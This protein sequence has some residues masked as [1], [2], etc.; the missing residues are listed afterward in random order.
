MTLEET[1][2]SIAIAAIF[3]HIA[4][5]LILRAKVAVDP[6]IAER[7]SRLEAAIDKAEAVS[8]AEFAQNRSELAQS[9]E[10]YDARQTAGFDRFKTQVKEDL[11][12]MRGENAKKLDEMRKTVDERLQSSIEKKFNESFNLI[13]ERLEKVHL[14]LGE[15]Q[16]LARDVGGL[17]SALTNVKTRG[18]FGEIQL[19]AILEQILSKEQ[20]YEQ[21]AIGENRRVD[22]AVRLPG[23]SDEEL[24]L[25]IDSK[26][27]IE[28]YY[29]LSEAYEQN[30]DKE[31]IDELRKN[32]EVCVK[33]TAK[34]ISE[35]Y[36]N[37]PL[38][39]D[40]ALMFLPS[41][42][43]YAE[44]LRSRGLFEF[45]QEKYKITVAGPAN[46]A[47]FLNSLRIGFKTLA[48]E[49]RS[50]EVWSLLGKVKK[51]FGDFGDILD[52]VKKQL[53]AA[54]NAIDDAGTRTRAIERKLKGV[55]NSPL[56]DLGKEDLTKDVRKED[57]QIE[58]ETL[59]NREYSSGEN[60]NFA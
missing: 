58:N 30:A 27:P 40:F 55:E 35:K 4:I 20:Y 49:K 5:F 10:L 6:A 52:R 42:S 19:G 46:I 34:S 22:F 59:K 28:D 18:T 36:I 60:A 21:R 9:F 17:K 29:R 3:L 11:L 1:L 7:L 38:T 37:P 50:G 14:G 45:L 47:A 16:K 57:L 32:L 25:P 15:M 43:L 44:V 2:I 24:L 56:E 31:T 23:G 48:I 33:A 51:D 53:N 54:T 8:R 26:F 39:T 12:E 13:G 41:E